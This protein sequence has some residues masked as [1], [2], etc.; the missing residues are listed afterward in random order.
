MSR[1]CERVHLLRAEAIYMPDAEWEAIELDDTY[2]IISARRA[3]FT[4]V[5]GLVLNFHEN[6][7]T[8]LG[9]WDDSCSWSVH[10]TWW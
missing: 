6:I 10:G 1:E 8:S 2:A 5:N 9:R 4:R 7:S 3:H